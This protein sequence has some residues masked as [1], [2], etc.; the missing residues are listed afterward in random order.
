MKR[1]V[2]LSLIVSLAVFL[3]FGN[4]FAGNVLNVPGDYTTIQAAIDASSWGDT[5]LVAPGEYVQSISL[6]PGVTVKSAEGAYVTTIRGDG[7]VHPSDNHSYTVLGAN[8]STISGFTI[9]GS[10]YGV[11]SYNCSPTITNNT[12]TGNY[13]YGIYNHQGSSPM[14]TGN[15]ITGN[16]HFGI[17]NNINCS[18]TIINNTITGSSW[19]IT[20]YISCSPTIIG[21]TIVAG[22]RGISNGYYCNPIIIN[23]TIRGG[24]Y[25]GIDNF[26]SSPTIINNTIIG[27]EHGIRN[28]KSNAKITNNIIIN[29]WY[30]I[31]N[32]HG[33]Y[34]VITYNNI[35]NNWK[36][37]FSR[38]SSPT[39][40]DNISAD[41]MLVDLAAGNYHLQAGS[42]CIDAGTNDAPDLTE[43]DLDGNL[44]LVDGNADGVTT[45]DMGAFELQ[46]DCYQA[47]WVE[48]TFF[49]PDFLW[50]PNH[51]MQD[52]RVSGKV[53]V[54]QGCTLLGA[55]Y[56]LEDEYGIYSS[57]DA[58]GVDAFGNFNLTLQVEQWRDGDDLDGRDYGISFFAEDEAGVG[59]ETRWVLVPLDLE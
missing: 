52:I 53:N 27:S 26:E 48:I 18:P 4:A 41:P 19:G 42:P 8:D 32:D 56:S 17:C 51:S 13:D 15:T 57:A 46:T 33:S 59:S 11:Y 30:G 50:P 21:N 47:P 44:R 20:N 36:G 37:I 3:Q 28:H 38:Y 40:S 34:P 22:T 31:Y 54:P 55:D 35:W 25:Y 29:S 2:F 49:G 43:T 39:I 58:L 16:Y 23:N 14:I 1:F 7:T 45:V 9:T 5:V 24:D 10:D 12:V 6:R